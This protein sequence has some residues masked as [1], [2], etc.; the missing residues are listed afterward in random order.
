MPK[1]QV[2]HVLQWATDQFQIPL[3]RVDARFKRGIGMPGLPSCL[4][5]TDGRT[6][7]SGNAESELQP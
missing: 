4:P 5:E 7:G 1:E 3:R 6:Q 2:L